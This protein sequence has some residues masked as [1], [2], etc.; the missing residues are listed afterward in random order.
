MKVFVVVEA[1]VGIPDSSIVRVGIGL[2]SYHLREGEWFE[3]HEDA[4]RDADDRRQRKI[5][6]VKK[7]LAR[8]KKLNFK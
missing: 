7:Q 6:S 2:H 1:V 8:L 4:L 3:H 5:A